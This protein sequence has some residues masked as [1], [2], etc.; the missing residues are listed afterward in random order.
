[1]P[2]GEEYHGYPAGPAKEQY[3]IVMTVQKLPEMRKQL[4][5]LVDEVC[6]LKARLTA[7]SDESAEGDGPA[8]GIPRAA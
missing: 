2:D 7:A 6:E 5:T 4:R 3:R 1:V 8:S